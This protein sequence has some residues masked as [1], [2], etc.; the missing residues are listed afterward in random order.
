M[1]WSFVQT[2]CTLCLSSLKTYDATFPLLQL[3]WPVTTVRMKNL[4]V[5]PSVIIHIRPM[6]KS[7]QFM[8]RVVILN[9]IFVFTFDFRCWSTSGFFTSLLFSF[10]VLPSSILPSQRPLCH[11]VSFTILSVLVFSAVSGVRKCRGRENWNRDSIWLVNV[12]ITVF[13][14]L[15]FPLQCYCLRT[16]FF[17]LLA[18]IL[19][20]DCMLRNSLIL[21]D[22]AII[23]LL[24]KRGCCS[25]VSLKKTVEFIY[26][27][28]Y[29]LAYFYIPY[30]WLSLPWL[31]A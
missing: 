31:G 11:L 26:C 25:L 1:S 16:D 2:P 10:V 20:C 30:P 22:K 24:M 12:T 8:N 18:W 14:Y 21:G 17:F 7:P 15:F 3:L 6:W 5:A 4:S 9:F 13:S 29:I 27:K 19:V 23:L 28:V